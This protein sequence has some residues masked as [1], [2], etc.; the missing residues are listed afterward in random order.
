MTMNVAEFLL[1]RL[2]TL[3]VDHV[4]GIPGDY[5]LAFFEI[6]EG[7]DLQHVLPCNELNG[8]YAADGYARLRGVGAMAVT[9]G[10]GAFSLVNAVAAAYAERS[11]VIV[12]SGGPP[13]QAYRD[14]PLMHHIMP[15]RYDASRK[16]FEQVTV[17]AKVLSDPARCAL[18][19]VRLLGV[20]RRR[21][22]HVPGCVHWRR[23]A[24]AGHCGGG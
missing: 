19:R 15:G 2:K 9:Y 3:G 7:S 4:F 14:Q 24:A 21:L 23:S 20:Y 18:H 10:P 8:G 12:I 22:W 11:P 5:I 1:S 17:G 13:I 16:I 6:L